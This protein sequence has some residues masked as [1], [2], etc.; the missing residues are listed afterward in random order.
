M[1]NFY[2]ILDCDP[3]ANADEL[4]KAW[5]KKCLENHP[6]TGGDPDIFMNVMHAYKMLTDE[7]YKYKIKNEQVRDLNFKIQIAVD[8]TEAFFGTSI[9]LGYNRI[10]LDSNYE[11]IKDSLVD[12]LS[13]V[14][15][16]PAG[17]N[18]GFEF[19]DQGKGMSLGNQTGDALIN[20]SSRKHMRY[21]VQD[22]N[23]CCDEMIPLDVMLKGGE[24]TV[25]TLWGI[26]TVWVP[27]GTRPDDIIPIANCGV[28][29]KGFQY[30]KVKPVFPSHQDLKSEAWS[31]LD[32]NWIRAEEK[33]K[34]DQDLMEKFDE[35][36]GN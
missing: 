13:V 30:C 28:Y 16:I 1:H 19:A 9:V 11:Q 7:S 22:L 34:E 18:N 25:E 17:S 8:F 14:I 2:K 32:I 26:K 33:N 29:Q 24:I 10:F 3:K 21:S 36:R 12:P 27:V 5:R 35:L 4:R 6:D 31:G 23:V 20:V 15:N